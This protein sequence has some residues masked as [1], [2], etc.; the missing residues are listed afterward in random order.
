VQVIP[1]GF[2]LARSSVWSDR[3]SERPPWWQIDR[4]RIL[5]AACTAMPYLYG[6]QRRGH[7]NVARAVGVH[8]LNESAGGYAGLA[9][10]IWLAPLGVIARGRTQRGAFLT[11]LVFVGA[12]GAFRLP[13]V[14]NVLRALPVLEVTD[15]RRLTLWVAFGLT[16]LGGMGLDQLHRSR[17]LARAWQGAWLVGGAL[18]AMA[19]I[20]IPFLETSIRDRTSLHYRQAARA[21]PG[22]DERVYAERADRQAE[23]LLG[24]LP[25]YYGLMAAELGLLA[26][27][28]VMARRRGRISPAIKPAVFALTLFDLAY[29][30][31]GLNP[32]IP[33]AIH[34]YEPPVIGRLRQGLPA[35]GRVLGLGQ[36]LPP[37]TLM[38]F[39]LNDPRNYDSVELARSLDWFRRLYEPSALALSSR[40]ETT[41]NRVLA[42][43]DVLRESAVFA[44]VAAVPPPAGA[45]D[46]VEEVGGVW[47]AW[48]DALPW[49]SCASARSRLEVAGEDGHVRIL[50]DGREATVVTVRETWEPGWRASLDGSPVEIRQESGVFCNIKIPAG[51]HELILDYDPTEI[52][53][54]LAVSVSGLVIVILVLTGIPFY[55]IPGVWDAKGLDGAEPSG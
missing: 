42:A 35:R 51:Q 27:L 40:G 38:R 3:R 30:G 49:A 50:V 10:L 32:A 23:S 48:C 24:F 33:R 45:F 31:V 53:A 2:Y 46:R 11:G 25:A 43:R 52:R 20:S 55:R 8:N 16:L 29:F 28:A 22:A 9:T 34:E 14:D 39:G 15:N 54:G 19:A 7:P 6:S 18:L 1:L 17:R 36:E 47:I 4:P 44:I 26:A 5:D 13:P 41:W 21:S 12:M 37:N